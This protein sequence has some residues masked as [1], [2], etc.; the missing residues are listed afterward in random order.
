MTILLTNDLN[1][2]RQWYDWLLHMATRVDAVCIAGD[3]VSPLCGDLMEQRRVVEFVAWRLGGR[4]VGLF[5]CAGD[6]DL[7]G[8]PWQWLESQA[9]TRRMGGLTVTSIPWKSRDRAWFENPHR[10]NHEQDGVWIVLEHEPPKGSRVATGPAGGLLEESVGLE[11]HPDYLVCGHMR[12]APW[13]KE[14]GWWERIDRTI[15][16]NAG[17]DSLGAFPAHIIL[18]LARREAT[19]RHSR[20]F[21]CIRFDAFGPR[22]IFPKSTNQKPNHEHHSNHPVRL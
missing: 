20:G 10:W 13:R 22:P 8:P 15:V 19:W 12:D 4:S 18:D 5:V 17:S 2:N 1:G 6:R 9:G 7:W 16:F 3:L 11:F 14:G 21:E